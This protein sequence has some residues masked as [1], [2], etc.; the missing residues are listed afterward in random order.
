MTLQI[1]EILTSQL[2]YTDLIRF[3]VSNKT[4]LKSPQTPLQGGEIGF[5]I[6]PDY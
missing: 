3:A 5:A 1:E 2:A 4:V 6:G